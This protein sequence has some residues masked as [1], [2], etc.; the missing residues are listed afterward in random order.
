MKRLI[1]TLVIFFPFTGFSQN[2]IGKSKEKVKKELQLQ[3]K[4]NDSL[5]ITLTD[6]DSVLVYSIKDDKV[7]AADFIYGF[8][9]SGKC[10]SE[11]V[12]AGCQAC[13]NKYLQ[14]TLATKKYGWKKINENQYVSKFSDRRMI[15]LP[16]EK[17]NFTFSILRTDWSKEMYELL[18][19]N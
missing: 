9:K 19:G 5:A 11:K 10:Q 13:F 15:E 4:K 6:R 12:I 8:D 17:K 1:I 16:D 14:A 18:S 3:L 2:F 7:L